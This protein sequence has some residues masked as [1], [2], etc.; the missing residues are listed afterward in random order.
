MSESLLQTDKFN[1]QHVTLIVHRDFTP[2][3]GCVTMP[4]HKLSCYK[5]GR[6]EGDERT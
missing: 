6:K 3:V 4:T 5:P 1:A 2:E